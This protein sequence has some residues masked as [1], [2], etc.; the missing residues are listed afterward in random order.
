MD[1]YSVLKVSSEDFVDCEVWA[2]FNISKAQ[3]LTQ[4]LDILDEVMTNYWKIAF[5]GNFT[6]KELDSFFTACIV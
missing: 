1:K 4:S 3:D 6:M 2:S 5:T